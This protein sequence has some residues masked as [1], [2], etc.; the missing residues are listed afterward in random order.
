VLDNDDRADEVES[1]TV[2]E[3]AEETGRT[4]T[5]PRRKSTMANG[6]TKADLQGTLDQVS[7][8]IADALDPALSRE[9]VIQKLQEIDSLVSDDDDFGS[10]AAGSDDDDDDD[11]DDADDDGSAD[12]YN[13]DDEDDD[14]D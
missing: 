4:I 13:S 3:W 11:E 9:E 14:Q 7:D 10:D 12:D 6:T 8:M 2:D 5:N 1:E